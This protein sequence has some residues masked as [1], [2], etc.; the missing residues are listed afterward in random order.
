MTTFA[1][2]DFDTHAV[3]LV[4]L[5]EE[6]A[7]RYHAYE[8]EGADAFERT[9]SVRDAMPPRTHWADEGVIA[10]GIELPFGPNK[11]RLWPVFGAIVTCLPRWLLVQPLTAGGW[12]RHVGLAGNASKDQVAQRVV[13]YGPPHADPTEKM[14]G[15]R[16]CWCCTWPQDAFDAFCLALAVSR[17]AEGVAA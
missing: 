2:I 12:R 8:L 16:K 15:R 13:D 11:G 3:H 17:L 14:C 5:D 9:R 6:G 1:G 4:L 7:A 10:A